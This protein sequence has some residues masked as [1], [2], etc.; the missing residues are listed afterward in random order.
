MDFNIED[1]LR[2]HIKIVA[3]SAMENIEKCVVELKT[4]I[5]EIVEDAIKLSKVVLPSNMEVI[6]RGGAIITDGVWSR[7]YDTDMFSI[8][9]LVRDITSSKCNY[10]FVLRKG[11]YNV[12]IIIDPILDPAPSTKE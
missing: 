5:D 2:E 12:T 11:S 8:Y 3:N 6:N 7:S 1:Q 10:N 9:D 4:R